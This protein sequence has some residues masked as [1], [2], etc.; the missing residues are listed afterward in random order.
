[1]LLV[2]C[3]TDAAVIGVAL[4]ERGLAFL[5]ELLPACTVTLRAVILLMI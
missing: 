2:D 1:V 4:P 5:K 3:E